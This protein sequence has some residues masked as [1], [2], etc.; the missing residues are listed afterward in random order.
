[1]VELL[2]IVIVQN[3]EGYYTAHLRFSD[4]LLDEDIAATSLYVIYSRCEGVVRKKCR[5]QYD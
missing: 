4:W 3:N 2:S 5:G 1:M